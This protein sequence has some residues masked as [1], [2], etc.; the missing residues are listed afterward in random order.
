MKI[1]KKIKKN[2]LEGKRERVRELQ[3]EWIINRMCD[4]L[5]KLWR[6]M[7]KSR[8]KRINK[9]KQFL[10]VKKTTKKKDRNISRNKYE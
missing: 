5:N 8:K 7:P 1:E 3:K 4:K 6:K 10:N 9:E 2:K